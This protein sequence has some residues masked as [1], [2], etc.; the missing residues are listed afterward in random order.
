MRACGGQ[1][2][3]SC[4]IYIYALSS[5]SVL[6]LHSMDQTKDT[7][8]PMSN[9]KGIPQALTS[10]HDHLAGHF[11][12]CEIHYISKDFDRHKSF[13]LLNPKNDRTYAIS[14]DND[15]VINGRR[16]LTQSEIQEIT[17]YLYD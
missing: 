13:G 1:L 6:L 7:C 11:P 9:L 8:T 15:D 17:T 3:C 12:G 10:F 16:E 14:L 5:S 2:H 4:R